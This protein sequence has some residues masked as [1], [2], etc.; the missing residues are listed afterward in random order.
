MESRKRRYLAPYLSDSY[1]VEGLA[2]LLGIISFFVSFAIKKESGLGSGPNAA[3]ASPIVIGLLTTLVTQ[4]FI[5]RS[6]A[7]SRSGRLEKLEEALLDRNIF[8]YMTKVTGAYRSASLNMKTSQHK[9]LY[10][11]IAATIL[12]ASDWQNLARKRL[13][14]RDPVRELTIAMELLPTASKTV[15]AI[16]LPTEIDYLQSQGGIEYVNEQARQIKN[17]GIRI[18][19]LF[20][21]SARSAQALNLDLRD[22]ET[23]ITGI[24][25][26]H[27][28][29]GIECRSL[30][31]D[32]V[33]VM[34]EVPDMNIYDNHTVRFSTLQLG[35]GQMQSVISEDEEDLR[36]LS[37][38]FNALWSVAIP[39]ES[40][41]R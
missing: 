24:A 8:E 41:P 21:Y 36:R 23:S 10:E 31:L 11:E 1:L 25:N 17:Q 13:E 35:E 29:L 6:V 15:R 7:R 26:S 18:Q 34:N 40:G 12:S 5:E 20:V 3:I 28:L 37:Q 33:L 38:R 9:F 30:N 19:R 32:D 27:S 22:L 16:S 2:L 14:I 4:N 39:T